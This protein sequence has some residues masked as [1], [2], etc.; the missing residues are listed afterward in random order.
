[1]TDKEPRTPSGAPVARGGRSG[2]RSRAPATEVEARAQRTRRLFVSKASHELRQPLAALKL[3]AGELEHIR[4]PAL[5]KQV[6]MAILA[7]ARM[8]EQ[9][10]NSIIDLNKLE[11]GAMEFTRQVFDPTPQV[12]AAMRDHA[13]AARSGAV[14]LRRAGTFD[15][16]CGDPEQ[17]RRLIDCLLSNAIRFGSGGKVLI[18]ARR[19]G[20]LQRIEFWDQG[21][22]I[23]EED[24][25]AV[26][27]P[28]YQVERT[29]A[30][31]GNGL[32]LGLSIARI[33][34]EEMAGGVALRSVQGRGTVAVLELP[35]VRP[36]QKAG[37]AK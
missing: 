5:Q 37:E 35:G 1:M 22:G 36:D 4:D 12:E 19:R 24:L 3:L 30:V 15:P 16:I 9:F 20:D 6:T 25:D 27:D 32:G 18:G 28:Y 14:T 13:D 26:F 31:A 23:P 11:I 21:L 8:M 7:S 34:A 17:F 33:I 2:E 29:T 10:V